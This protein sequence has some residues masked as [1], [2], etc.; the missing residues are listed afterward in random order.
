MRGTDGTDPRTVQPERARAKLPQV[1]SAGDS[2]GLASVHAY[3]CGPETRTQVHTPPPCGYTH[4]QLPRPQTH[5]APLSPN[6]APLR[7]GLEVWLHHTPLGKALSFSE[8]P[9]HVCPTDAQPPLSICLRVHTHP[10]KRGHR[11]TG[12]LIGM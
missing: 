8:L 9:V 11:V 2:P 4:T 5:C 3:T 7:R 1:T 6:Q 10:P 12:M